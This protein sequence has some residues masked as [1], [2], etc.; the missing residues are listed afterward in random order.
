MSSPPTNSNGPKR[1]V[2]RPIWK[3]T[4]GR[5]ETLMGWTGAGC[6][7][8]GAQKRMPSISRNKRR[9]LLNGQLESIF[10]IWRASEHFVSTDGII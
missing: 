2:L 1:V 9:P 6:V 5:E 8:A 7:K 4:I 10:K 3:F